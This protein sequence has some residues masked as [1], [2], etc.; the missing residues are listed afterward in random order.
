MIRR[1]RSNTLRNI[2]A[3]KEWSTARMVKV[4]GGSANQE[5]IVLGSVKEKMHRFIPGKVTRSTQRKE[6][7]TKLSRCTYS[8]EKEIA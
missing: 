8:W 6:M 5:K 4:M 7:S 2:Q 1:N 3:K